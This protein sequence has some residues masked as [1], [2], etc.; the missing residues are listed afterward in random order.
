VLQ[1]L[2]DFANAAIVEANFHQHIFSKSSYAVMQ[3]FL[4]VFILFAVLGTSCGIFGKPTSTTEIEVAKSFVLGQ[5]NHGSYNANIK[6]ISKS[7]VE[8][9]KSNADGTMVSLGILAPGDEQQYGVPKD[10]KIAFMNI[11]KSMAFIAIKLVGDTNL[12]MGYSDNKDVK[13]MPK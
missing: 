6:N 13:A 9:F 1:R 7:D 12:S 10:T 3:K 5:G 11:G 2:I 8:V 4:F